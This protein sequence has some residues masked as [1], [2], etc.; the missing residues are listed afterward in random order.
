MNF[1]LWTK[2]LHRNLPFVVFSLESTRCLRPAFGT[3][4]VATELEFAEERHKKG[5]VFERSCRKS[6]FQFS[7][8]TL[9]PL[10]KL[11]GFKT[12]FPWDQGKM[13]LRLYTG[14][15]GSSGSALAQQRL[16]GGCTLTP[17]MPILRYPRVLE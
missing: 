9:T 13:F 16:S 7:Q 3:S 4:H 17:N 1:Q 5:H 2:N 11:H 6:R 14:S 12:L 15:T 10:V 8:L